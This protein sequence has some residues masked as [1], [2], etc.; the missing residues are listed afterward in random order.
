MLSTL[1]FSLFTNNCT[2]GELSVKLLK[3]ADDT[4]LSGL[5]QN[6]DESAYRWEVEQL[7]ILC[8]HK[9][10]ELNTFKTV[11]MTVDFRR[12]LP[13]LTCI[14]IFNSSVSAV[15]LILHILYYLNLDI[16]WI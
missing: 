14:I 10:L 5:I 13:T 6:G 16:K 2:S 7:V 1:L 9:N 11:A 15:D 3:F 12:S 4:T 8:S